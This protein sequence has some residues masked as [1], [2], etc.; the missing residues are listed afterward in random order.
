[1]KRLFGSSPSAVLISE[2]MGVMPLP[3]A[4]AVRRHDRQPVAGLEVIAGPVGEEAAGDA[5]DGDLEL[6]VGGRGAQRIVAT[7]FLPVDDRHDGEM[8]AGLEAILVL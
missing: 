6:V 1:V 3:P 7:H 4:K 8:L 2:I 5:L